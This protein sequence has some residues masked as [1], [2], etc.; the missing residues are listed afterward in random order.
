VAEF[1]GGGVLGGL[2]GIVSG[3]ANAVRAFAGVTAQQLLTYL[4][5]LREHLLQLSQEIYKGLKETAKALARNV[6]AIARLLRDGVKT[7]VRWAVRHIEALHKYLKDKLGPA[8]RFLEKLRKRIDAFYKTYVRPVLDVIDFIRQLNAILEVFHVHVLSSLDALLAAVER[9]IDTVYSTVVA[10]INRI[11]NFLDLVIGLDGL[12]Q[13]VTLM[14]SLS[15]YRGSWVAG[16]WNGQID[17][18]TIGAKRAAIAPPAAPE[19]PDVG[20]AELARFYQGQR[21]DLDD[22]LPD[23][24]D[25]FLEASGARR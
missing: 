21:S 14:T 5:F 1:G 9:K 23:L 18:V 10:N 22:A 11:D 16:F 25:V 20:G 13:R 2:A 7:F 17:T 3:I 19:D 24:R 4:K 12:Y 6:R 8:L 15:R